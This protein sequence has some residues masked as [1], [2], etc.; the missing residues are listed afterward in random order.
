MKYFYKIL[1]ICILTINTFANTLYPNSSNLLNGKVN[2][3]NNNSLKDKKE[4][5]VKIALELKYRNK[6]NGNKLTTF[7]IPIRKKDK[8]DPRPA[9]IATIEELV[10][11][12]RVREKAAA[13]LEYY[14]EAFRYH[15]VSISND[16][17][18]V[19]KLGNYYFTHGRYEKAR[20]VFSKNI[21][22]I[23]NLFGAAVTNRFL[24]DYDT[25]ILY[26]S[27]V[28]DMN[29]NLAEPYLERGLCYRNQEKYREALA[30]LLKYKKMRNTEEAYAALGNLYILKKDYSNARFVLN[31]GKI[32]YPNSKIIN[33]LL[34]KSHGK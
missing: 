26:Y 7:R 27:E 13:M 1:L 30:D 9:D 29:P 22:S 6:E 5:N 20:Q 10:N 25:A 16:S 4:E 31:D 14:E 34:I 12:E 15:L 32:L 24:G 8:D 18:E 2:I 17:K 33:E 3:E 23:E 21:N 11:R 19:Y 28:I